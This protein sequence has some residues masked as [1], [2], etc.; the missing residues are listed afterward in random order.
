MPRVGT[1]ARGPII[2]ISTLDQYALP[3]NER[4]ASDVVVADWKP[5]HAN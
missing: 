2:D 1:R 4:V 3:F 5:F